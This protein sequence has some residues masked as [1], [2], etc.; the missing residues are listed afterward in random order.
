VICARRSIE[1]WE[2]ECGDGKIKVREVTHVIYGA[3]KAEQLQKPDV[4]MGAIVRPP[5]FDDGEDPT[6]PTKSGG[7]APCAE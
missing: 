1:L 7:G 3:C 6:A 5:G 2:K 4:E